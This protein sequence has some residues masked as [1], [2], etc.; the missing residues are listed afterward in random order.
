MVHYS[1]AALQSEQQTVF[2][3]SLCCVVGLALHRSF[4][5][6]GVNTQGLS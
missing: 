2:R 5:Q 4:P 1:E 3:E 6:G